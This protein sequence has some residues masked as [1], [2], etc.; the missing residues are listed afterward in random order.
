MCLHRSVYSFQPVQPFG[1]WG[2]Q[3]QAVAL[4]R[5]RLHHGPHALVAVP[6]RRFVAGR[7]TV[8]WK[9]VDWKTVDWKT[10]DWKAHAEALRVVS[11]FA[12][13]PSLHV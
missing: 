12:A 13:F 1:P 3:R 2:T 9:T 7:K 11:P 10:V 5:H 8:D 6:Q 4:H